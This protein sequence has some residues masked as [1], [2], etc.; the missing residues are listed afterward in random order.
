MVAEAKRTHVLFLD[1]VGWES[2]RA[3]A[4][5]VISEVIA[6][7]YDSG[8]PTYVTSGLTLAGFTERYG[9]AIVRRI[10]ECGG[11]SGKVVDLWPRES[12]Q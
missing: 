2:R 4:D 9:D 11:M 8:Y 1:D 10:V 5:D 3:G 12:K 7:R 6:S